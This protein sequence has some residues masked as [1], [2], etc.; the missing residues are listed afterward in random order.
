MAR[1]KG[2]KTADIKRALFECGGIVRQAA[3]RLGVRADTIYYHLARNKSLQRYLEE[4]RRQAVLMAEQVVYERLREGDLEAA[5]M[6]LKSQLGAPYGWSD[7]TNI[8]LEHRFPS[9]I[10]IE[11]VRPD[12]DREGEA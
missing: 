1:A 7:R 3:R 4:V 6:I 2:I 11:I 9:A 5:R 8:E 12:K 10:Q